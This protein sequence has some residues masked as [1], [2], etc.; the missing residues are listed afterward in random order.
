MNYTH[1]HTSTNTHRYE[2]WG[3]M[4][5]KLLTERMTRTSQNTIISRNSVVFQSDSLSS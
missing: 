3:V 2:G 1:T 4:G 5:A